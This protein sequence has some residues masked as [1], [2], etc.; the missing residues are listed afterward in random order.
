MFSITLAICFC[1]CYNGKKYN[2][3]HFYTSFPFPCE[4]GKRILSKAAPQGCCGGKQECIIW[5]IMKR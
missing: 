1:L 3:I 4:K 2:N 5:I